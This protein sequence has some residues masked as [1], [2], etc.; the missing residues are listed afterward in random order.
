MSDK[1]DRFSPALHHALSLVERM[2]GGRTAIVPV[3]PTLPMVAA[4]AR[5]G[6]V[7]HGDAADI[8]RAMVLASGGA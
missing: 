7:S 3:E 6:H 4:G 8:Y 5:A 1:S 2:S